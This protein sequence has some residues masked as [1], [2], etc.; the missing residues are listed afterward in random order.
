MY[1]KRI[2]TTKVLCIAT[3]LVLFLATSCEQ[4][5]VHSWNAEITSLPTCT[6]EGVI[7][8]K[9]LGCNATREETAPATGHGTPIR[10]ITKDST[11]TINGA[12]EDKCPV[13]GEIVKTGVIESSGHSE[14]LHTITKAPTCTTE[15]SFEDK[16]SICGEVLK[17]GT[18]EKNAHDPFPIEIITEATCTE[19]G[20]GICVCRNCM[21]ELGT[22]PY[23][24]KGH[25]AAETVTVGTKPTCTENGTNHILCKVCGETMEDVTVEKLGHAWGEAVVTQPAT[26]SQEGQAERSCS[27]C[28]QKNLG[29]IAKT[30]HSWD[31][32][33]IRDVEP[34]CKHDGVGHISCINCDAT[35][36][37]IFPAT[38]EHNLIPDGDDTP[39]TEY[40]PAVA[41]KVCSVCGEKV[42]EPY[43]EPLGHIHKTA[44]TI[45]VPATCSSVGKTVQYCSCYTDAEGNIY[46]EDGE[47]RTRYVISESLLGIDPNSHSYGDEQLHPAGFTH[48]SV[49]YQYC[50]DCGQYTGKECGDAESFAGTWNFTGAF[51]G[52]LTINPGYGEDLQYDESID[53]KT[54]GTVDGFS[55]ECI[56][57]IN[58]LYP[59]PADGTW[60]SQVRFENGN[61]IDELKIKIPRGDTYEI[62]LLELGI[63]NTT[64]DEF[65]GVIVNLTDHPTLNIVRS[66]I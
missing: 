59:S 48:G 28:G 36:N 13:C 50:P 53:F 58:D 47:G 60:T 56:M 11:C 12:F 31:G 37:V 16:C 26:C 24:K 65:T 54:Y 29:T 18:V 35:Q 8:Y 10:I 41:H 17:T 22:T 2:P 43:G 62:Y 25:V 19:D 1:K 42:D 61:E 5:H 4:P 63:Q 57:M 52:Y 15:G 9:C 39:A 34:D 38:G 45:D 21:A 64:T 40:E 33:I 27:R 32:N 3:A 66:T 14:P 30:S 55:G 6:K 7:T 20:M 23:P 49:A 51:T 46:E 44:E